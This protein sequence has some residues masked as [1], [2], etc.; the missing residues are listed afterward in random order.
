MMVRVTARISIVAFAILIA[1][2]IAPAAH[3][4]STSE[5]RLQSLV[6]DTAFQLGLTYRFNVTELKQRRE[7]VDKAL[8]AWNKSS[9]S[10]A[11]NRALAAWLRG[12]MRAS[13]P[14]SQEK[15]PPLPN[16]QTPA[17]A[18]PLP[19]SPGA[20]NQ[21]PAADS[22]VTPSRAEP[23][24]EAPSNATEHTLMRPTSAA[25]TE[26]DIAP[27]P[28]TSTAEPEPISDDDFWSDHPA[29]EELPTDLSNG[30]PF[31]DDPLPTDD[32]LFFE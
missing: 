17:K 4:Q 15:L 5:P 21:R 29:N 18:E 26:S 1:N 24:L 30:D 23:S 6:D 3:A 10:E 7:Q 12:A 8:E 25:V 16:F 31:L 13:M 2:L 27:A 19:L 14:G 22:S 11:D 9:R 32:D 20:S 28:D